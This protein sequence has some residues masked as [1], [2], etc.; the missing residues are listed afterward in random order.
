MDIIFLITANY[1]SA[2]GN[3]Y[4][5]MYTEQKGR[6]KYLNTANSYLNKLIS[7]ID[8]PTNKIS[9]AYNT[10]TN[11]NSTAPVGKVLS[12]S[13]KKW[14][15]DFLKNNIVV[16]KQDVSKYGNL[17]KVLYRNW[18]KKIL[19]T[20]K[21]TELAKKIGFSNFSSATNS[22][23]YQTL[24][25]SGIKGFKK[26][27]DSIPYDMIANLGENGTELQYDVSKGVL[28]S[29]GQGDMIFTAEQ[30]KTLMEFAKNPM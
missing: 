5:K 8:N 7:R 30:A 24:H 11:T 29:V 15:N 28:K 13:Q 3:T 4:T 20:S 9:P 21:W 23:F 6:D 2:V 16:A 1:M 17:N 12:T 26:G 22:A 10:T 19:P 18:G 25:R 27:S 14:V